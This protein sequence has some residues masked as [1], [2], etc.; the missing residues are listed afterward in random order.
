MANVAPLSGIFDEHYH[1]YTRIRSSPVLFSAVLFA[2]TRFYG[3]NPDISIRIKAHTELL[4]QRTVFSGDV[5]LTVAQAILVL[6]YWMSPGDSAY[7]KLGIAVRIMCQLRSQWPFSSPENLTE[8]GQRELAD[9]ERTYMSKNG[10]L[11][12]AYSCRRRWSGHN[13]C[14]K[15]STSPLQCASTTFSPAD[16]PVG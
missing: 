10:N 15:A 12:S 8:E 13:A 5:N 9:K 2:S 3:S 11:A 7:Q 16:C 6:V 1:T 14:C 4:L